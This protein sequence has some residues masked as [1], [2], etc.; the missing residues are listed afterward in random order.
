MNTQEEWPRQLTWEP[1][2]QGSNNCKRARVP[3]GYLVGVVIDFKKNTAFA[4]AFVPDFRSPAEL[5][6]NSCGTPAEPL[7]R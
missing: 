7:R 3:G 6:Q 5:L 2:P 4:M 1:Y